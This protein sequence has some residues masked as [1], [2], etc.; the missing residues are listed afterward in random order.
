MAVHRLQLACNTGPRDAGQVLTSEWE[1][2]KPVFFGLLF[3]KF[4][5][6]VK[7]HDSYWIARL[8]LTGVAAAQLRWHLWNTDVIQR[9]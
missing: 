8:C 3:S 7:T 4:F 5:S 2:I 9:I 6:I 1:V